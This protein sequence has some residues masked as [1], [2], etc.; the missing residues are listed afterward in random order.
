MGKVLQK[1]END[2]EQDVFFLQ[3]GQPKDS[4]FNAAVN[5]G[6][7]IS[8]IVRNLFIGASLDVD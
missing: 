5:V 2:C 6:D 8:A 7:L 4:C 3:I 1:T